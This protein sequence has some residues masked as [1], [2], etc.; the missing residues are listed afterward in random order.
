MFRLACPHQIWKSKKTNICIIKE[1][2]DVQCRHHQNLK[3]SQK[4]PDIFPVQQPFTFFLFGLDG[5]WFTVGMV[6][7][8]LNVVQFCLYL[9]LQQYYI[10]F[11]FYCQETFRSFT[12]IEVGFSLTRIP[13]LLLSAI[14]VCLSFIVIIML[15]MIPY[16]NMN[17]EVP[18][19]EYVMGF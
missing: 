9:L 18:S 6:L 1:Q 15:T 8:P 3:G 10:P 14:F 17:V 4:S 5:I 13:T 7:P 16:H 12:Q 11:K 19:Q 2:H